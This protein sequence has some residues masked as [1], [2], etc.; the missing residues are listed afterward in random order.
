MLEKHGIPADKNNGLMYGKCHNA[1]IDRPI[2][3]SPS[4]TLISELTLQ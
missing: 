1:R 3:S 4:N 2:I